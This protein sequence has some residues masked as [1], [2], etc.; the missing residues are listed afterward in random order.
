MKNG[1]LIP[2]S[3]ILL[4]AKNLGNDIGSKLPGQDVGDKLA[5]K[6]RALKSSCNLD[7]LCALQSALHHLQGC[8]QHCCP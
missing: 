2:F 6:V 3:A 1:A 5:G 4:Q 7:V 8:A